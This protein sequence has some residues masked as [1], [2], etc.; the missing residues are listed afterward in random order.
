MLYAVPIGATIAN[1]SI[2]KLDVKAAEGMPGVRA[3][4]HRAN[5]GKLFRPAP[6]LDFSALADSAFTDEHRP[7]FEDDIIRYY[8]TIHCRSSSRYV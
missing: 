7:P 3:I 8:G 4:Y 2:A 1:G 5:F 6:L